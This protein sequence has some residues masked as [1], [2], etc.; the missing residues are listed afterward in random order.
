MVT[1][2]DALPPINSH[3][4]LNMC[5]REVTRQIKALYLHHRS[6]YGHK[7]AQRSDKIEGVPTHKFTCSLSKVNI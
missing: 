6:T 3:N 4:P 7:I 2:R 5:L 1:Q